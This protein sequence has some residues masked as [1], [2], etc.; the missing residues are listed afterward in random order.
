MNSNESAAVNATIDATVN[1][2]VIEQY[3]HP[4]SIVVFDTETNGLSPKFADVLS[5]GWLKA[6]KYQYGWVIDKHVERFVY[7]QAIHNVEPCLSINKI[8]DAY[9][10]NHGYSIQSI[11]DEFRHDTRGC[12]VFAFN[13]PFDVNFLTKYDPTIFSEVRSINDI[14]NTTMESVINSIQ[15]IVYEYFGKFNMNVYINKHLHTAYDDVYTEFVILL[16]DKFNED[17]RSYFLPCDEYIP[18]VGTGKYKGQRIDN[19]Y[20]FNPEWVNW[21]VNTKTSPCEDYLRE[22]IRNEIVKIPVNLE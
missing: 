4:F 19:V 11:L 2:T 6:T 21:F 10:M 9:R 7:N 14:R 13:A 1:T 22:Y 16:H 20:A 3:F 17:V 15:R 18:V 5:V 12:D 8:T